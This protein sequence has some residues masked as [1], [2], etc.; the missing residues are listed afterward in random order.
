LGVETK[1]IKVNPVESVKAT[2]AA[3][4]DKSFLI[5]HYGGYLLEG[6]SRIG[7]VLNVAVLLRS[8]REVDAAQENRE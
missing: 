5:L 4:P 6:R 3:Y 7:I 8:R 1:Q 2:I